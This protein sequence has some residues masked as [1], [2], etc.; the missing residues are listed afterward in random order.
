MY[1]E[2]E[3]EREWSPIY[4]INIQKHGSYIWHLPKPFEALFEVLEASLPIVVYVY[5]S[6]AI[7]GDF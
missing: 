7:M 5:V 2:E 3:K 6:P 4:V 1:L